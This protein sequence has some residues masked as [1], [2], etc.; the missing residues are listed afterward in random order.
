[1]L[2]YFRAIAAQV[3]RVL[4]AKYIE[5]FADIQVGL[6]FLVTFRI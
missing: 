6:D 5:Y 1:M 2:K 4:I 3:L